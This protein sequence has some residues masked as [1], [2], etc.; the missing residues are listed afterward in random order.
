[1]PTISVDKYRLFEALGQQYTTE[2]FD[3][4]CFDFGMTNTSGT[5]SW[6]AN[7]DQESSSMKMYAGALHA[8]L[9]SIARTRR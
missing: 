3:Q 4:L 2:E 7:F 9:C 5:K 8:Q 6:L 1:M